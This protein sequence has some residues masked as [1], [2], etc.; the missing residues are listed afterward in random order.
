MLKFRIPRT[1]ALALPALLLAIACADRDPAGEQT[2]D[3]TEAIDQSPAPSASDTAKPVRRGHGDNRIGGKH[4]KRGHHG[5]ERLV[6][7]ALRNLD[8]TD[9][10]RKT[11]TD[12][13][14]PGERPEA[15]ANGRD[16]IRSL[17]TEGWKTGAIDQQALDAA[18]SGMEA[19]HAKRVAEQVRMVNQLHQ[20]LTPDQRKAL[21]AKLQESQSKR[22]ERAR[23]D[24]KSE[25]PHGGFAL[26]M[27]RGIELTDGQR[28]QLEAL[29]PATTLPTARG[30]FE[31]HQKRRAAMLD[32]FAQDSFDAA[33][34]IGRSENSGKLRTFTLERAEFVKKASKV[35]TDEQRTQLVE[36]LN[37]GPRFGAKG[38]PHFGPRG[39]TL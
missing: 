23:P 7:A 25:R 22:P 39:S 38:R 31:Q 18:L 26:G 16:A 30:A 9:A 28:K 5:P 24:A 36:R 32:A 13:K 3:K 8:L 4:M 37:E 17:L 12:L 20:T 27:L 10:Q 6:H 29:A 21:V 19:Q 33:K 11:L 14:N 1:S 35:L 15:D 34:F 2:S